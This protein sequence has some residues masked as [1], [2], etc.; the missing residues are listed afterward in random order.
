[1]VHIVEGYL[2]ETSITESAIC[3]G[4]DGDMDGFKMQ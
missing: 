1:M 4:R 2:I 3:V